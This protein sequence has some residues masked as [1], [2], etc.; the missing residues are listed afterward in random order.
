M[1]ILITNLIAV[2]IS[3]SAYS[4]T[5]LN[6]KV[7]AVADGDTFTM[8][9]KGNKQVK[10]RLHGIDCPE[11]RQDFGTLAKN[12]TSTLVFGKIVQARVLKKD[13]YKRIIAIVRLPNGKILNQELL[14][15]G[16]AWHYKKYD[17]S[18]EFARLEEQARKN[19]TG[20]WNGKS[21]MQPWEFRKR[22]R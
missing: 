2:L 7:I 8:L 16:M 14:K 1:K 12:Y 9:T 13:Q 15:A 22:I 18:R 6:G 5:I 20:L 19:K 10:I 17:Q 11:K 3:I 21:P 4:Q